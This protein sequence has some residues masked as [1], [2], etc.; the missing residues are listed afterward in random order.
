[1]YLKEGFPKKGASNKLDRRK[2]PHPK[3][4]LTELFFI[5]KNRGNYL[6]FRIGIYH[7]LLNIIQTFFISCN[8]NEF[9]VICVIGSGKVQ[10]N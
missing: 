2:A 1:M 3:K 5:S 9:D 10:R 4:I 7:L 8:K 6:I